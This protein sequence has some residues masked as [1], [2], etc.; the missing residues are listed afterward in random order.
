MCIDKCDEILQLIENSVFAKKSRQCYNWLTVKKT[1]VEKTIVE[2]TIV[3]KTIVKKTIVKKVTV[4]KT[5]T[6][7]DD[8]NIIDDFINNNESETEKNERNYMIYD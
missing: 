6:N 8:D 2:K 7:V 5:T 3:K 1:I 4:E